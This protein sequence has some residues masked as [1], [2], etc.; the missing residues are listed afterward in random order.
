MAGSSGSLSHRAATDSSRGVAGGTSGPLS[1]RVASSSSSTPS[2]FMQRGSDSFPKRGATEGM[3]HTVSHL[4]STGKESPQEQRSPAQQRSAVQQQ[5][6]ARQRSPRPVRQP[7]AKPLAQ[8]SSTRCGDSETRAS[9]VESGRSSPAAESEEDE[10]E[11]QRRGSLFGK[12]ADMAK[13]ACADTSP[14]QRH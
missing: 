7:L 13:A 5:S 4:G 8:Q 11:R 1:H 6:P 9:P 3:S 12:S 10:P 2:S 14:D